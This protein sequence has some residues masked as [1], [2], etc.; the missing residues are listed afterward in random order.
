MNQQL[1]NRP[2]LAMAPPFFVENICSCG[3]VVGPKHVPLKKKK[4]GGLLGVLNHC[5][6]PHCTKEW[7]YCVLCAYKMQ[8]A[9]NAQLDRKRLLA[10]VDSGRRHIN[11]FHVV[12]KPESSATKV[13]SED[14]NLHQND[15]TVSLLEPLFSG[16]LSDSEEAFPLAHDEPEEPEVLMFC[17]PQ[18]RILNFSPAI[19]KYILIAGDLIQ[20]SFLSAAL[21]PVVISNLQETTARF[22]WWDN[23]SK[24]LK[25]LARYIKI[26]MVAKALG[27]HDKAT[28]ASV[29]KDFLD[30]PRSGIDLE[31]ESPHTVEQFSQHFLNRTNIKCLMST[32]PIP[33]VEMIARTSLSRITIADAVGYALAVP[34][35]TP[36]VNEKN[37]RYQSLIH[38]KRFATSIQ[39]LVPP[40]DRG[41][42]MRPTLAVLM[43]IWTDGWDP[44]RL[45]K[46]N[47]GSVWSAT[48]CFVVARV[49]LDVTGQKAS[50]PTLLTVV[51]QVLCCGTESEDHEAF[52]SGLR[53]EI[54]QR[55]VNDDGRLLPSVAFCRLLS[56]DRAAGWVNLYLVPGVL[57]Q[58]NPERR[59]SAGLLKGNSN[60]HPMFGVSCHFGKLCRPFAACG[61]CVERLWRCV[62]ESDFNVAFSHECSSCLC[63]EIG[64]LSDRNSYERRIKNIPRLA[65]TD[66]GY[67]R[68]FQAGSLSFSDLKAAIEHASHMHCQLRQ[69][70]AKT[71]KE[72]LSMHCLNDEFIDDFM[73]HARKQL[74]FQEMNVPESPI[75]ED[76]QH[77]LDTIDHAKLH[78]EEYSLMPP[79][80]VWCLFDV[81]DVVETPM[82]L[83]Q[84]CQKALI[85]TALKY[86]ATFERKA[87]LTRSMSGLL[88][89]VKALNLLHIRAM[90]F[91][92]DKFG[93]YVAE[94]YA[95][96][97]MLLPWLSS[98]VELPD[99]QP[100]PEKAPVKVPD[101]AK[102]KYDEWTIDEN[103]RWMRLRKITPISGGNA[104][105]FKDQVQECL[106]KDPSLA[107]A[108]EEPEEVGPPARRPRDEPPG[109]LR[110]L[111]LQAHLLFKHMFS[112]DLP[113]QRGRNRMKAQASL[114]LSLWEEVD[115][116]AVPDREKPIAV[117]KYNTLGL[118]RAP[119]S[120]IEFSN[121]RNLH[122]GGG[123]GE[124]IVKNLRR[125]CPTVAR[126]RWSKNLIDAFYRQNTMEVFLEDLQ[127]P[128]VRTFA[129]EDLLE[130]V[131]SEE[132]DDQLLADRTLYRKLK[133]WDATGKPTSEHPRNLLKKRKPFSV[134]YY[135]DKTDNS[136]SVG[137]IVDSGTIPVLM[138][139]ADVFQDP[140]GFKY[141]A[142]KSSNEVVKHVADDSVS[143]D[144]MTAVDHGIALPDLLWEHKNDV[145]RGVR[146]CAFMTNDWRWFDGDT[147]T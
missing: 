24:A 111:L 2:N 110:Q 128:I 30:E 23:P 105:D 48:A 20:Q 39:H 16:A 83:A 55:H 146:R 59:K 113:G 142:V 101:P 92:N 107:E 137:V 109:T 120:F 84:N 77:R 70:S 135:Q 5:A 69:W 11:K 53:K 139:K 87:E 64:A 124:G 7:Y 38:S 47:R 74:V 29:I 66:P 114:F 51:T 8:A 126:V 129:K 26:G 104:Q 145:Q 121:L 71:V 33:E 40:D 60:L 130:E 90:G 61:R 100:K 118:L 112:K 44:N 102:K 91:K 96:V 99:M 94:S 132:E 134:T 1:V 15:D 123:M 35:A 85:R 22:T 25:L 50:A 133:A 108:V 57:L 143:C 37:D 41:W 119:E 67:W 4:K 141:I 116:L 3:Y 58:D 19:T 131:G 117:A 86:C 103:K 106:Q 140:F 81:N 13:Q 34:P 73:K 14:S 98:V 21:G 125:L 76:E 127:H 28:F 88:E 42:E 32:L 78:P 27:M 79:M 36:L 10:S 97:G 147:F 52:F 95:A 12:S 68:Q 65:D 63:W 9:G 18:T 136:L 80:G 75:W 45:S 62:R 82:H 89:Q 49:E 56:K 93:G 138:D 6:C 43:N 17:P 122:E 46:S 144:G 54:S 72:Y 115:K 31:I